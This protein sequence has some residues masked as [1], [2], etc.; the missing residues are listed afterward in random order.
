[1]DR[2]LLLQA[3]FNA[4]F[5]ILG[6]QGTLVVM[7]GTDVA[8]G[9]RGEPFIFE[10]TPSEQGV[11]TEFIRQCEQSKRSMHPLFSVAAIGPK[12]DEICG[13]PSKS[14]FGF[15]SPYEKLIE[16]NAL[17][18][19]LGVDVKRAAVIRYFEQ[20]YGVPYCYTKEWTMPVWRAGKKIKERYFG[21]VRYLNC[22]VDHDSFQF[23]NDLF[24]SNLVKTA[25]V[26]RGNV[27]V[28]NS[29]DMSK[30]AIK[31]LSSDP[32]YFL[33]KQ[34]LKEPWKR[35]MMSS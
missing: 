33:E 15:G 17:N 7:S 28:V 22:G 16:A 20:I 19:F 12:A 4:F 8:C 1:M 9:I 5:T 2:T 23:E 30:V 18:V 14:A 25:K 3:Y 35:T 32:F 10:E 31:G 29:R 34:P 21:L 6:K 27:H 24:E 11:L 13:S 26:G